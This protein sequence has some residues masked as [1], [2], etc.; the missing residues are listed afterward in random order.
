[1]ERY[2]CR[3]PGHPVSGRNLPARHRFPA[4]L[5]DE[6]TQGQIRYA[7]LSRE[8]QPVGA[9]ERGDLSR[10]FEGPMEPGTAD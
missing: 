9:S 1:M 8:H 6:T 5:P 10:H 3:S 4:R 2:D 7:D